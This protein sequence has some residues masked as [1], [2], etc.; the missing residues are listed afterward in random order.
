MKL[1]NNLV[2]VQKDHQTDQEKIV[3]LEAQVG[4]IPGKRKEYE[5]DLWHLIKES[6]NKMEQ[7]TSSLC[8]ATTSLGKK[9]NEVMSSG[10]PSKRTR[11]SSRKKAAEEKVAKDAA[12]TD[13]TPADTILSTTDVGKEV[14][15]IIKEL[16]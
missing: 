11:L 15:N 6:G 7:V 12:S 1:K 14:A 9:T 3:L 8:P 16:Q 4:N 10:G 2:K 5:Q 13:L